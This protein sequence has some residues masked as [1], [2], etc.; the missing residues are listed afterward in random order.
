MHI[1]LF[2][3][4]RFLCL[5]LI[6]AIGMLP[7]LPAAPAADGLVVEMD[8]Y[9]VKGTRVLPKPESWLYIKVPAL[10][11]ETN[12][13]TVTVPGYEIISTRGRKNTL[14]FVNELQ[15]RQAAS[16]ILF[17]D[18]VKGLPLTPIAIVLDDRNT[19]REIPKKPAP[20][21]WIGDSVFTAKAM[22]DAEIR[23][24]IR[25][26]IGSSMAM[27]YGQLLQ[28]A[29]RYSER[30]ERM[31]P[32]DDDSGFDTGFDTG[33]SARASNGPPEKVL[34]SIAVSGGPVTLYLAGTR[35][36]R[37]HN[38]R[39]NPI[40]SEERLAREAWTDLNRLA[41]HRLADKAPVWF[42]EGFAQLYSMVA[43]TPRSIDFG[44]LPVPKAPANNAR[45]YNANPNVNIN[46]QRSTTTQNIG[47][48]YIAD[49]PE[50]MAVTD[51]R[52]LMRLRGGRATA[53]L[54]VHYCLY[55][56]NGKYTAQF[57]KF[58]DRLE[59][60]PFSEELFQE[61]FNGKVS[62]FEAALNTYA[63][64]FRWYK[65]TRY[66]GKIPDMPK[67]LAREAT[68]SE[69]ARVK[70]EMYCARNWT[71]LALDELRIAYWRGEREPAMLALL[72][73][74]EEHIGSIPRAE[75]I[76]KT[77]LALPQPPARVHVVAAKLRLRELGVWERDAQRLTKTEAGSVM[78]FLVKAREQ[79]VLN[80][81]LCATMAKLVMTSKE[82]PEENIAAFIAG[83]AKHYP[84]NRSIATAARRIEKHMGEAGVKK[85]PPG[86][87]N[88][89]KQD[90]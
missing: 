28:T 49:I 12:A 79:G 18:L 11:L 50:L 46:T 42:H 69:I 2:R 86:N 48:L 3:A 78:E 85:G 8:P 36:V 19:L 83:A 76:T 32:D 67:V 80:E 6:S 13:R 20:L 40:A 71:P 72:A 17:P 41:L 23:P 21:A 70:A 38:P 88:R 33:P 35:Y 52:E 37:N 75:K 24:D 81:D 60:E 74:L 14:L 34:A 57:F 15:L 22:Q 29:S 43:V 44:E 82:P 64:D 39:V 25:Y 77:L 68:Q 9:V 51:T 31:A 84:L 10:V 62:S 26:A 7:A 47:R 73:F 16:A 5:F 55:G 4:P 54:F 1:I 58:I 61:C 87:T 56:D 66:K 53:T 90:S 63:N 27:N 45:P 59:T 65:T 30:W 89:K